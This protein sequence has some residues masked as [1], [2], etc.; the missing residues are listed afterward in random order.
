MCQSHMKC[1]TLVSPDLVAPRLMVKSKTQ[2]NP[3]GNKKGP[4]QTIKDCRTG[5]FVYF[6]IFKLGKNPVTTKLLNSLLC[7]A[8]LLYLRTACAC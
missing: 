6:V 7:I 8:I 1:M 3:K 2:T 4:T 5:L